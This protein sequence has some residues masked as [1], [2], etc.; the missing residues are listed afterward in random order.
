MLIIKA[1]FQTAHSCTHTI[2]ML[3]YVKFRSWLY[4][5]QTWGTYS[6][7]NKSRLSKDHAHLMTVRTV[8]QY[9]SCGP[10]HT[11]DKCVNM[12]V[13][14]N[15]LNRGENWV[16][17]FFTLPLDKNVLSIW[18]ARVSEVPLPCVHISSCNRSW[19]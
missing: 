5:I 17:R 3:E 12:Y 11:T 7:K 1:H 19:I 18:E 16:K 15:E 9:M 13:T 10:E 6:A 2:I 8:V 14:P 4:S